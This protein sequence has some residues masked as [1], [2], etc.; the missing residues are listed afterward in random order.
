MGVGVT[1]AFG[2]YIALPSPPLIILDINGALDSVVT[3]LNQQLSMK[4]L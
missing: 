3:F 2:G 4:Q 1:S